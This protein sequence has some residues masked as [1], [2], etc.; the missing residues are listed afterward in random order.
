VVIAA[1]LQWH[2]ARRAGKI[3]QNR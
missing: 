2:L 1:L 3:Y